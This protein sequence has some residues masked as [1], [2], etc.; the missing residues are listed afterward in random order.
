ML[1]GDCQRIE[2]AVFEIADKSSIFEVKFIPTNKQ[3]YEKMQLPYD[4]QFVHRHVRWL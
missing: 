4:Y 3:P 2:Q 1:S